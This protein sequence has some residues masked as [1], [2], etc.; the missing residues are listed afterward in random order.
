MTQLG[1]RAIT[2]WKG[3]ASSS[4]V[5]VVVVVEL[6]EL[7]AKSP[8]TSRNRYHAAPST[9]HLPTRARVHHSQTWISSIRLPYRLAWDNLQH[10][11]YQISIKVALKQSGVASTC[12]APQPRALWLF[13]LSSSRPPRSTAAMSWSSSS[14]APIRSLSPELSHITYPNLTPSTSVTSSSPSPAPSHAP[15]AAAATAPSEQPKASPIAFIAVHAGAGYLHSSKHSAICALLQTACNAALKQASSV[16]EAAAIA[17]SVLEASPLTNAGVG[18]C[19]TEDGR[20]ECE[21]SIVFGNGT[22]GSVGAVCGVDHSIQVAYQLA[23]E[24]DQHG[25]IKELSRVR[26][27]SLV[28]DGAYQ[29]AES[30]G[31]GVVP[32]EQLADHHVTDTTRATWKR[33]KELIDKQHRGK[34][35][36]RENEGGNNGHG[37]GGESEN[38]NVDCVDGQ[39]AKRTR[40]HQQPNVPPSAAP[41]EVPESQGD[42]PSSTPDTVGVVVCDHQGRVCAASSSGGIWMKHS[43]RLGS[44]S[45]PGSGCYAEN[46]D[47][48][49]VDDQRAE[50][51]SSVAASVSGCGES[52]ME[53]FIAMRCCAMLKEMK[54]IKETEQ[55]TA[56]TAPSALST[57]HQSMVDIM[58]SL[59]VR[60]QVQLSSN[61]RRRKRRRRNREGGQ[62][63]LEEDDGLATGLIT[64]KAVPLDSSSGEPA[65]GSS[66]SSQRGREGRIGIRFCWAHTARHFAVGFAGRS[67]ASSDTAYDGEAWI[68]IL[69]EHTKGESDKEGHKE[70]GLKMGEVVR[71][72]AY[73]RESEVD[74]R[75]NASNGQ[76]RHGAPN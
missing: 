62:D 25:L 69:S 54:E 72:I 37:K 38:E 30:R 68:S 63:T 32:R 70:T 61:K 49:D 17:I 40:S 75:H 76:T 18:S 44:S 45:M 4:R 23:V 33:Y 20:V 57:R 39:A 3:T 35:V 59:L 16:E 19:L 74:E 71:E 8:T 47:E 26:P 55:N 7:V 67:A 64:L 50:P 46:F 2:A 56:M 41:G 60:K 14:D 13:L 66:S 29:F 15:T 51:A 42:S 34:R 6:E 53:Q 22:F 11:D 31:L 9:R 52:V 21:A 58:R 28:G 27:I 12:A 48:D 1:R 65:E 5:V 73:K 43:G 36:A 10:Q 24:R